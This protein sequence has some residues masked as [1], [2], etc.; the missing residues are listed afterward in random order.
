MQVVLAEVEG[1]AAEF[2]WLCER[3]GPRFARPEGRCCICCEQTRAARLGNMS[4]RRVR[5]I[6]SHGLPSPVC[7]SLLM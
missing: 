1:W 2:E 4:T 5:P 6:P 3:I 7:A